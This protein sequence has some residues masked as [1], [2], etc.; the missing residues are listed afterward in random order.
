MDHSFLNSLQQKPQALAALIAV[1]TAMLLIMNGYGLM[2]GVTNVLPHLFYIPI[3]LT[4]YFFPRRG[5]LFSVI[6]S[7]IYGGITYVF[8]PVVS[9]VLI[10]A[11]GRVCI[12]ILIAA[13]VSFLTTRLRESETQFRGVAERSSDIILLAD[14]DGRVSYISPSVKRILGYEP[15]E[16]TGKVPGNYIHPDDSGLLQEAVANSTEGTEIEGVTIR[17]IKKDGTIAFLEFFTTPIIKAGQISG[18]QVVGRDVTERIQAEAELK[19]RDDLLNAILESMIAGVVLIDPENHTI[20]DVNA[21]AAE[22]IG[23]KKE[24]I[25]GSVCTSYIC[26]AHE[27]ACPITD[28]H[29]IVDR[30]EQIL[31]RANGEKCPVIKS[32][33]PITLQDRTYLLESFIDISELARTKDALLESEE[34]YRLLADYT[35]DWEYWID[36]DESIVYTTPSCEQI[37]GYTQQEFYTTRRLINAILHP[38]DRAALEH[39]M[40]QAFITQKPENIDFRIIHRDGSVRWIG[41]V[42]KPIFNTQGECIGR[43]ASNRDI[44]QRKQAEEA[45]RET[46]RRLAEIIDF[47]PDPTMVINKEGAVVAWNRAMELMSGMPK[48]DMLGKGE[49]S[50][51]SWISDNTD[52]LLIACVLKLDIKRIITSYPQA[53]FEGNT[54]KTEKDIIR[55]DGT[56]F[57]LWISATPLINRKGEITGAI[58]S[59]RDVTDQKKVQRALKESNAY[60][61]TVINTLADPLFI[62]DCE[63]RFVKLNDRFCQFTGHSRKELLGK[64][65]YDFFK[66]EEADIF[67]KIDEE[68]FRT[69]IGN[70][71]EEDITDSL[72]NTHTIV[73][74]KTLYTNS[75]GE[76]FIVGI[77]RDITERKKT[78][79]ALQQALKKLNM[80]SSITRHDILNQLMGLRLY[81]EL[82][83]EREDDPELLEFLNKGEMSADAIR[84]QIEFTR[85]YEDL[86][87][88]RP[89]WQDVPEIFLSVAS[90]LPLGEISVDVQ[91]PNLE[92]YADPLIEK[93]FY[94]LIENSLR[95]GSGVTTLVLDAEETPD[96]AVI[97]YQDNGVGID[98]KDKGKLFQRGFGKHTGLGL[99]LSREILSITNISITETGK[100]GTG[101]RFEIR[102]PKGAYRFNGTT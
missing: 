94:N 90:Q 43:R 48:A 88:Q 81:L 15:A 66:K 39:H 89:L 93:V 13:V 3:I 31:L 29:E 22:M 24:E 17:F 12:F 80:L 101:V 47:L 30:S 4:A 55:T 102:V 82:T 75:A 7:A 97:T 2:V 14:T 63:F 38:E 69:G 60:L 59:V 91:V 54:V 42:C 62:K 85:Y 100:P 52:P 84:R 34:K 33:I 76:V 51:K 83:K 61:D 64:T 6:V 40:S 99:F 20:K 41:H 68:V 71:N 1:I 50:Y 32:V 18:V 21:V 53:I 36:A 96:G 35:Y 77:I 9:E 74:K 45:S 87:V 25:I 44:T 56:R 92:V 5:V 70:E 8:N 23:A 72:G 73:T 49:D 67:R 10:S 65:D 79:L 27:G 16:I 37:T 95:H 98:I 46:S 78:E 58:E 28:L 11:G 57:S 26:P 86:G 19:N